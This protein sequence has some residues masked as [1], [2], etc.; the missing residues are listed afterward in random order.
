MRNE[1][2]QGD[3]VL[4]WMLFFSL[5]L[6]LLAALGYIADHAPQLDK[7]ISIIDGTKKNRPAAGTAKAKI[8]KIPYSKNI[9]G[10]QKSQGG[11]F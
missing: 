9:I 1:R 10:E 3:L 2:G 4:Y 5:F 8:K 11:K 6:L 7:L